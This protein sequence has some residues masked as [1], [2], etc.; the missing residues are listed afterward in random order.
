MTVVGVFGRLVG[1]ILGFGIAT[2]GILTLNVLYRGIW[3]PIGLFLILGALFSCH[4][5]LTRAPGSAWLL[6]FMAVIGM[7]VWMVSVGPSPVRFPGTARAVPLLFF[8]LSLPFLV[9]FLRRNSIAKSDGVIYVPIAAFFSALVWIVISFSGTSGGADPMVGFVMD[10]LGLDKHGAELLIIA[11]RK[12]VH[13]VGYGLIAW[14]AY[15]IANH[16]FDVRAAVLFGLG[17]TLSVAIFDEFRQS[18]ATNRT[19]SAWDVGLDMLGALT[20]IGISVLRYRRHLQRPDSA[21]RLPA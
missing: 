7:V 9:I 17:S 13:F 18:T 2:I 14:S 15:R 1:F 3:M 21:Q 6:T 12:T 5:R 8:L 11:F 10:R 20:F 4:P 19:G 16:K